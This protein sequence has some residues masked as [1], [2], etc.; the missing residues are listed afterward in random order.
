MKT[1]ALIS[2]I[3]FS[4]CSF[5]AVRGPGAMNSDEKP[6]CTESTPT[7]GLDLF[8]AVFSTAASVAFLSGHVEL[9]DPNGRHGDWSDIAT[10]IGLVLAIPAMLYAV[11]GF[12]GY[13]KVNECIEA[14]EQWREQNR[15][16]RLID[17]AIHSSSF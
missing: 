8:G 13:Q 11:S 1:I 16:S 7:V 15:T 2:A 3:C 14:N 9:T 6:V 12:L 17:Q 10:G 4:G 5:F